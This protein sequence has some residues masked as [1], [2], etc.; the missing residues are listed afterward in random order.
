MPFSDPLNELKND[1]ID[2]FN[3]LA[4]PPALSKLSFDASKSFLNEP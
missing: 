3:P 4:P 1:L 2:S